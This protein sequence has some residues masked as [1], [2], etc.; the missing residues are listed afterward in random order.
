MNSVIVT[1][2]ACARKN[3]IPADKQHLK[4][5]CGHCGVPINLSGQAVS[6]EL[7]DHNFHNFVKGATLPVMIDFYSPTCG[8]CRTMMPIVHAMAP[9]FANRA[10]VA[11]L[12]TSRNPQVASFFNIRGVPSFLFFKNGALVDQI[13]GA[14]GDRALEQKLSSLV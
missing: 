1:C 6:V 7:D 10:I 14:V 12:D 2:A 13:A 11:T 3:K 9:K 4:P 5:K 8:P